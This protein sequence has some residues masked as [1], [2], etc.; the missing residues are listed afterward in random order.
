M[1]S[2]RA[3]LRRDSYVCRMSI[4]KISS[5]SVTSAGMPCSP[6]SLVFIYERILGERL[7]SEMATD[8]LAV[9]W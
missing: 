5:E 6:K 8:E 1:L 3:E 7:L 4:E 2:L 9:D